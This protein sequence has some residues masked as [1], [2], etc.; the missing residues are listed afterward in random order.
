MK[1][2]L[3]TE[4][5][6]LRETDLSDVPEIF[7]LHT[8]TEVQKYTGEPI[9]DTI[10]DVKIAMKNHIQKNFEGRG[11]GRW[12]VIYKP[13]NKLIGWSGLK[14]LT[15]FDAVDIGYRFFLP[16]GAKGL[17]LKPLFR[18]SGMDLKY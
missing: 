3:E 17:Q 10:E 8:N 9:P 13:E 5:L 7:Q 11:Y 1:T 14:Y 6:L 16:I 12:A 18:L 2:I 4:R 15:E